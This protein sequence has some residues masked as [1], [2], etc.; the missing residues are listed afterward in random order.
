MR[1]IGA[2]LR[3]VNVLRKRGEFRVIRD[4]MDKRHGAD[5]P[6]RHAEECKILWHEG[7]EADA[8]AEA[9][10]RLRQG[11]Y[12]LSHILAAASF[13]LAL[14]DISSAEHLE[15]SFTSKFEETSSIQLVHYV[16]R[17]LNGL[18]TT[19]EMDQAA[20]FLLIV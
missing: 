18:P 5:T 2:F 6:R 8:Q 4:L 13:T 1:E 19:D 20:K 17:R 14:K 11:D 12:C 3:K 7:R 10:A 15:N 16:Y 9:I